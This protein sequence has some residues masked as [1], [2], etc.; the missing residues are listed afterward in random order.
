MT[1][2]ATQPLRVPGAHYR[3][4]ADMLRLAREAGVAAQVNVMFGAS[5]IFIYMPDV[6]LQEMPKKESEGT[7]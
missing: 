2:A 3:L 4:V 5:G 7:K 6:E 1:A